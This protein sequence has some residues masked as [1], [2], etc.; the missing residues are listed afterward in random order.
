LLVSENAWGRAYL[1]QMR[2]HYAAAA[3]DFLTIA[4]RGASIS[5]TP[6][7]STDEM[8]ARAA[9]Q[10]AQ[11]SHMMGD[12]RAARRGWE[13]AADMLPSEW[14]TPST[15]LQT[16]WQLAAAA[17]MWG[18]SVDDAIA[19]FDQELSDAARQ[20]CPREVVEILIARA[21]AWRTKKAFSSAVSDARNA[22]ALARRVFGANAGAWQILNIASLELGAGNAREAIELVHEAARAKGAHPMR[23]G[24]GEWIESSALLALGNIED[25]VSVSARAVD[26]LRAAENG[27]H[28]GASLRVYA[29]AAARAH[30]RREAVTAIEEAVELLSRFGLPGARA[31]ALRLRA[32]ILG[33]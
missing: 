7:G 16:L 8:L 3:A 9:L 12:Y 14:L 5:N 28:L 21:N 32:K 17:M 24:F 1:E 18:R 13:M 26:D 30:R 11:C 6:S 27:R 22:L 19:A 4:D 25:A 23:D 33:A 10:F 29:E 31:N 20:D 15:R 2:G